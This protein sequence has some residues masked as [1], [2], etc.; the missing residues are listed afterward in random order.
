MVEDQRQKAIV[1]SLE[2]IEGNTQIYY[3]TAGVHTFP[4]YNLCPVLQNDIST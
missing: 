2:F 4:R 1:T 3:K